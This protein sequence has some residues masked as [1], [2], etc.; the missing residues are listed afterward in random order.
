LREERTH[1][2]GIL[3]H[4]IDTTAWPR[5]P[6]PRHRTRSFR[7][8]TLPR[9]SSPSRARNAGA[10]NAAC[11]QA[12]QSTLTKS[13]GPRFSM[14]AAYTWSLPSGPT[15]RR[16]SKVVLIMAHVARRGFRPV[17]PTRRQWNAE[18]SGLGHPRGGV[19]AGTD[20][21]SLVESGDYRVTSRLEPQAEYHLPDSNPKL[22]AAVVDVETTGANPV[23]T[24]SSNSGS[25]SPNM[26]VRAGG[27]TKCFAPG[28]VV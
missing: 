17:L 28:S 10:R 11:P 6:H 13:S 18:A 27:S 7:S 16:Q 25:V 22:V 3:S 9:G 21:R 14:L 26:T 4:L 20:G 8:S 23:A 5:T 15:R 2:R 19:F 12:T 1:L 24:R